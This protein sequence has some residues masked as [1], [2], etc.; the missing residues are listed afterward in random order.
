MNKRTV[1]ISL[2]GT[3]MDKAKFHQRW[4]RW[5]PTVS[6]CQQ[7]DL[8][9]DR[10]ELVHTESDRALTG[11]IVAD[12]ATISPETTTQT[13][14]IEWIDPWDFEEVYVKLHDFCQ[15]YPFNLDEEDYL[16][17]L[18]TG[19]HVA[20][21]CW[22]LLTESRHLPAKIIQTA[23][24]KRSSGDSIGNY[25][26]IDLDLS[27]YD[28]LAARYKQDATEGLTFL[29]SGI[30][31]KNDAFNAMIE[32]I[33]RVAIRSREPILLTGPTGAGK[34]QL[35]KRIFSLKKTRNQIEG[36]FVAV[37]CGTLRGD[38]AI[39]TLFGHV[40]G[41]FTGA[42]NE[43]TGLLK[44]ADKGLL[45]LDEIGELGLDEQ[46]MLLHA[47]EEKHFRRLGADDE[48]SS[49][50]QL[51]A[52]TNRDLLKEVA[53]GRFRG[54][55]LAR[56]NLWT[57][58]MPGLAQRREDIAPNLEYE[59]KRF[60]QSNGRKVRFN[61]EA[62]TSYLKFGQAADASWDGNFR[63]LNASVIRMATLASEQRINQTNVEQEI[64]RLQQS[65][66]TSNSTT[67]LL[68]KLM[69]AEALQEI[70]LFDRLQLETVLKICQSCRTLSEAGRRLYGASRLKKTSSNDSDRLKKYLSRF[71]LDWSAV[72]HNS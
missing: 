18:T 57:Y 21:I 54:D 20:Q 12:I 2:V 63:D 9:I 6:L 51:I 30:E 52:G 5:R 28:K 45:F 34:S 64:K 71:D 48:I 44:A 31:T 46:A 10:L 43:R 60:E 26:I 7:E 29:K 13:H 8:I 50:F 15:N 27:R 33:E 39:S 66:K 42:A 14:E 67:G 35:A 16:V 58:Q 47:V 41:A 69:P 1:C 61:K 3:V 24:P 62:H 40:K 38:S 59:L 49:D 70:D 23:P 68:E 37:N 65:W 36:N 56:I 22:F 32:E 17:H 55:L 25:S 4:D 19:T 53:E 11:E 72:K